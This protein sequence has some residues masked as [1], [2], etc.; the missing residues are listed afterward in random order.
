M[1]KYVE[2]R[3]VSSCLNVRT[4]SL[5]TLSEIVCCLPFTSTRPVKVIMIKFYIF[6]SVSN[7]HHTKQKK[8]VYVFDSVW[9]LNSRGLDQRGILKLKESVFK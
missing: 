1:M 2:S 4:F 7:R 9:K 8:I 5:V 3:S 6:Y